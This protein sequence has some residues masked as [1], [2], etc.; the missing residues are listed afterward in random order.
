[1]VEESNKSTV[2]TVIG[3]YGN[4]HERKGSSI[5]HNPIRAATKEDS[6]KYENVPVHE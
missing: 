2:D 5:D 1:M 6:S 3:E 4:L